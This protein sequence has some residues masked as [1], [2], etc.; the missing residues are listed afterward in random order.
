M[1]NSSA[2]LEERGV[3]A[4]GGPDR[5][6]FL[7]GLVSNDV[8]KAGPDRAVHAALLTPQ[9]KYLH[10][11]FILEQDEI[12]L[13]DCEAARIEDLLRRLGMYK[14]RSKV[15]LENRTGETAV[16]ALFGDGAVQALGLPV[17]P[18]AARK[19][20]AGAVYVD[21]R[22]AGLGARAILPRERA[23]DI[24]D[25]TGFVHADAGDYDAM[26]LRHGVSD[27]TRDLV[28]DKSILLE[29][30]F[31]VLNGISWDKGCYMGQ[32]LTA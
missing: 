28:V 11:F 12:L 4:V 8:L 19:L 23:A 27:G 18:G 10:D 2:I 21:P 5:K 32:E 24:L 26:R 17:E 9:G 13:L 3:L 7:Q 14:L 22:L 1:K 25:A 30:N 20:D 16:A 6:A 29:A 31:D 15:T